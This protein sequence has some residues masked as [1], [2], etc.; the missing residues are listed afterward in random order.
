ML[1]CWIFW[2]G[3]HQRT[4]SLHIRIRA[5]ERGF[6]F[7]HTCARLLHEG[8]VG[9]RVGLEKKITLL[10]VAP[11]LKG[12]WVRDPCTRANLHCR[13]SLR[14]RHMLYVDGQIFF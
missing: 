5:G 12:A 14:L 4:E 11:S 6:S 8:L 2:H 1:L 7:L 3:I 13:K 10:H 9:L